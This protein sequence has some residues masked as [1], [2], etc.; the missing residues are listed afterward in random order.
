MK[1]LIHSQSSTVQPLKGNGW[2]ISHQTWPGISL[3]FRADLKLDHVTKVSQVSFSTMYLNTNFLCVDTCLE[4]ETYQVVLYTLQ[5]IPV[6]VFRRKK[7]L[8]ALGIRL[9]TDASW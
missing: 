9:N 2:V 8:Q 1:L 6:L 4:S 7:G 5:K 3:L